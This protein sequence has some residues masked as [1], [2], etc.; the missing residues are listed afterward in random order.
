[1]QQP[2][3]LPIL[4]CSY[5]SCWCPGD[6]RS[7]CI[8]RHGID[9][10]SQNI[11]SLASEEYR[12]P[13]ACRVPVNTLNELHKW[14]FAML[15]IRAVWDHPRDLGP[16]LHY[17]DVIMSSMAYQITGVSMVHSAVCSCVDQ[18]KRQSSTWL[19]FV[20]GIPR[21][22]VNSPHKGPVTRKMFPFD[23]VIMIHRIWLNQHLS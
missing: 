9:Q 16:L 12:K 18:R 8:S 3:M 11:S 7:Q 14:N 17:S 6:L 15:T 19:A 20:R 13:S 1:M 2:Y 5:H 21:W 4:Y 23:Y 10:I 22:P